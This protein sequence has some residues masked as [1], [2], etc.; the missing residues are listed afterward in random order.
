M[1]QDQSGKSVPVNATL[2]EEH[3]QAW[4]Y[5]SG[6]VV[7]SPTQVP[8]E[9]SPWDFDLNSVQ[10]EENKTKRTLP[11]FQVT[12]DRATT[13]D[14][15]NVRVMPVFSVN[16]CPCGPDCDQPCCTIV[17]KQR[18]APMSITPRQLRDETPLL[19]PVERENG[20]RSMSSTGSYG[21]TDSM[22]ELLG[23]NDTALVSCVCVCVCV[24]G[25]GG[26]VISLNF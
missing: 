21:S 13:S 25:G 18:S 23:G 7:A 12:T 8:T 10:R 20:Q 5:R 22:E 11:G 15:S 19:S 24:S 14:Y 6:V 17:V 2:D 16:G 4:S 9:P 1:D 26:G 3:K